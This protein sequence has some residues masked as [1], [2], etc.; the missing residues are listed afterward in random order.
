MKPGDIVNQYSKQE[1]AY[2]L[3]RIDCNCN[4]C[5]FMKRDLGRFKKWREWDLAYQEDQF[6]A[7]RERMVEKAFKWK[8]NGE[9]EKYEQV[10]EEV[11]KMKF[12]YS[13]SPAE[14]NYGH[15]MKFDKEVSFIPG[16][17]QI[18]TQKCFVH[19]KDYVHE[20]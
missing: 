17:C 11:R 1:R 19:R 18:E 3:Q 7:L 8:A 10:M 14:I 2:A 6:T 4:D 20:K 16:V 13:S 12:Q 5:G 9:H 15:C